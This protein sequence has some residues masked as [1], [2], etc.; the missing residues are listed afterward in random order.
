MSAK[1]CSRHC[2]SANATRPGAR[3][4]GG[5]Y[6]VNLAFA[7]R[8]S[9]PVLCCSIRDADRYWLTMPWR[10]LPQDRPAY[11]R[12]H[13]R[14]APMQLPLRCPKGCS[15]Q[16]D[17]CRAQGTGCA[18]ASCGGTV[19]GSC[20]EIVR[21]GRAWIGSLMTWPVLRVMQI[22]LR[23]TE[24]RSPRAF[25]AGRRRAMPGVNE[26]KTNRITTIR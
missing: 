7:T 23:M 2:V 24:L 26:C 11:A 18:R 3:L 16:R 17:A 13:A 22:T 5:C 10:A 20:S 9:C 15:F 14:V 1:P 12:M 25:L 19:S 8:G 21:S 4:E 6:A